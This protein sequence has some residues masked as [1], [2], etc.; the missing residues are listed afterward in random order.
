[1]IEG[2]GRLRAIR[3]GGLQCHDLFFQLT[4]HDEPFSQC[5]IQREHQRT[6]RQDQLDRL[7]RSLDPFGGISRHFNRCDTQVSEYLRILFLC[8]LIGLVQ[9]FVGFLQAVVLQV[10]ET[11]IIV[12]VSC[13]IAQLREVTVFSRASRNCSFWK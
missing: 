2:D 1:M 9:T 6:V 11:Q 12:C 13:V 8:F 3:Q 4:A 7:L 10:T 5:V